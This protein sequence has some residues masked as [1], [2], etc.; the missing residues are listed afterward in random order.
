MNVQTMQS[1]VDSMMSQY[2]AY[3]IADASYNSYRNSYCNP[4]IRFCEENNGGFYSSS[5][6]DDFLAVY[7]NKLVNK[8]IGKT[9]YSTFARIVRLLKSVSKTGTADFSKEKSAKQYD[10]SPE[11][12]KKTNQII[13]SNNVSSGSVRGL[14]VQIRHIFCF[15]EEQGLEDEDLNDKVFFDF[16]AS[17]SDSHKSCMGEIMRAIRLT[18]SYLRANGSD[19]LQTD[20]SLLPIKKATVRMI[21]P[22]SHE[23]IKRIVDA[24]DITS[25]LGK[26]DYAIMLLAFDTGLRGIDIIKL[27]TQDID[28]RLK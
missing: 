19:K 12:W 26:R 5:M 1:I 13:E 6:L 11:H 20:F 8:E 24:I 2:K 4:I 28:W 14:Q 21:P 15:I 16:L 10:P 17:V 3:G 18:T 9:Y 25:A 7:T 27:K 22:Y 23:E